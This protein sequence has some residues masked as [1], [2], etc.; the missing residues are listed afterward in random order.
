MQSMFAS[1]QT[2]LV[3]FWQ[4]RPLSSPFLQ[5]YLL[6]VFVI[7]TLWYFINQHSVN[8]L[9]L[10]CFFSPPPHRYSRRDS[11]RHR[12]LHHL[13][14]RVCKNAAAVRWEGESSQI[15]RHRWVYSVWFLSVFSSDCFTLNFMSD[16]NKPI[17]VC[18][19]LHVVNPLTSSKTM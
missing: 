19:K 16:Y 18:V 15:Q 11:R 14:H 17:L 1:Y 5:I 8:P 12:D 9:L 4:K 10:I 13:P 7:T 2:L 6:V 3:C